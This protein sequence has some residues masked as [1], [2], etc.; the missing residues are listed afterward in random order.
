MYATAFTAE[1]TANSYK[2]ERNRAMA[3]EGM[4]YYFLGDYATALPLFMRALA[5][6]DID[7]VYSWTLCSDGINNIISK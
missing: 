1:Q 4:C 3:R 6:I 2:A 7:D 5:L